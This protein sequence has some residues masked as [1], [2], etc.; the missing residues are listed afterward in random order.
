MRDSKTA[1]T[2]FY[3]NVLVLVIEYENGEFGYKTTSNRHSHGFKSFETMKKASDAAVHGL[4]DG[5]ASLLVDRG[6]IPS[7]D[8][9]GTIIYPSDRMPLVIL[10]RTRTT[11][12]CISVSTD[13]L[14]R[15]DVDPDAPQPA[16]DYTTRFYFTEAEALARVVGEPFKIYMTKHGWQYAK[17]CPV[18][19]GHATYF[20]DWS[21]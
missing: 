15:P 19:I 13:F 4:D 2:F 11:M 7:S 6:N 8:K 16:W 1:K 9:L 3:K 21:D 12:T 20:R 14:P 18:Q 5:A 10:N 17:C